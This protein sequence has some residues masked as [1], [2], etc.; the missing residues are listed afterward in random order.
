MPPCAAPGS[1]IKPAHACSCPCDVVLVSQLYT[2]HL[3]V[4]HPPLSHHHHPLLPSVLLIVFTGCWVGITE[5]S[6]SNSY[7][8][9]SNETLGVRKTLQQERREIET[10]TRTGEEEGDKHP[11]WLVSNRFFKKQW[12]SW[13]RVLTLKTTIDSC[14][15]AWIQLMTTGCSSMLMPSS[16]SHRPLQFIDGIMQLWEHVGGR[17]EWRVTGTPHPPLS[18]LL[19]SSPLLSSCSTRSPLPPPKWLMLS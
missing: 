15:C 7:G 18:S 3:W 17:W 10:G 14:A 6:P 11:C 16:P 13:T 12:K 8:R 9:S 4:F 2:L 19:F 1:I 5:T